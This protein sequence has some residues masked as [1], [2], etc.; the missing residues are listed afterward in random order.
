[1][2]VRRQEMQMAADRAYDLRVLQE[3][4]GAYTE[5]MRSH[6]AYRE[7]LEGNRYWWAWRYPLTRFLLFGHAFTDRRWTMQAEYLMQICEAGMQHFML[8][9][10]Q[11]CGGR[12]AEAALR[13]RDMLG[14]WCVQAPEPNM[15][16]VFAEIQQ[17]DRAIAQKLLCLPVE[18]RDI[19]RES[20]CTLR[21][22]K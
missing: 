21:P 10:L 22:D 19:L 17:R 5:E 7:S 13:L 8:H 20:G 11:E 12:H 4:L 16:R 6:Q 3:L 1:M 14:L 18:L 9:V 2:Y 15:D